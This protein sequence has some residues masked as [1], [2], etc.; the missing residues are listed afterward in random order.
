[1]N[2]AA[3]PWGTHSMHFTY[4]QYGSTAIM[5]A[6][7]DGHK[8]VVQMLL[9]NGADVHRQSKVCILLILLHSHSLRS[10]LQIAKKQILVLLCGNILI[11][12]HGTSC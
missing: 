10:G 12:S 4:L 6:A 3:Y 5:H 9:S 1:M 7:R 8:D 11:P 2:T